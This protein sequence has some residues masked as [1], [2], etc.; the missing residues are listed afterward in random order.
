MNE[1]RRRS[2]LKTA[3]ASVAL[4]LAGCS[5]D[6][7]DGDG[8]STDDE[9]A[10][11]SDDQ[12]ED[13]EPDSEDDDESVTEDDET[14]SI[15]VVDQPYTRWI[16]EPATTTD[17]SVDRLAF[18]YLDGAQL[19]SIEDSLSE[20]ATESVPREDALPLIQEGSVD[21]YIRLQTPIREPDFEFFDQT[22][23]CTGTFDPEAI[24]SEYRNYR[25][26]EWDGESEYGEFT[27][28]TKG[29]TDD[30]P[31]LSV[32]VSEST[33]LYVPQ[34]SENEGTEVIEQFADAGAGET[35][36]VHETD[37]QIARLFS[38]VDGSSFVSFTY[39]TKFVNSG[40]SGSEP[41][42]GL[43]GAIGGTT[44]GES[45]TERKT[46]FPFIDESSAVA[47]RDSDD[48]PPPAR[49]DAGEV[50][51]SLDGNFYVVT[52]TLPTTEFESFSGV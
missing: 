3:A 12:P 32:G 6:S 7:G 48:F 29:R 50:S 9:P 22:V 33:V 24:I 47:A 14:E 5:E 20:S 10:G 13:S 19:R 27:I 16:P 23:I 26:T 28:L 49:N 11:D 8:S 4:A 36:R 43:L 18:V 46:I 35:E 2:V 45:E 52:Q 40:S 15:T 1:Q 42:E 41:P 37:D 38:K 51:A 17:G 34:T 31:G 25:D 30:R 39:G 44:V 21:E